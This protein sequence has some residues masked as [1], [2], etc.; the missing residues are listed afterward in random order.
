MK[1]E[2]YLNLSSE[3]SKIVSRAFMVEAECNDEIEEHWNE[4]SDGGSEDAHLCYSRT[5]K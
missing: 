1:R 2:R 4:R 5:Q 3:R